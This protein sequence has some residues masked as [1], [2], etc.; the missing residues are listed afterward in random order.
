MIQTRT[1]R[2]ALGFAAFLALAASSPASDAPFGQDAGSLP[3]SPTPAGFV[4]PAPVAALPAPGVL[5]LEARIQALINEVAA[6]RSGPAAARA[7]AARTFSEAIHRSRAAAGNHTRRELEA[8]LDSGRAYLQH[9]Q[10]RDAAREA[11]VPRLQALGA[12]LSERI[13]QDLTHPERI[14]ADLAAAP[15]FDRPSL[16]RA[17]ACFDRSAHQVPGVAPSLEY[18]ELP[19]PGAPGA[20]PSPTPAGSSS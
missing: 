20:S 1:T 2:T 6:Y 9:Q 19:A 7:D 16:A 5:D 18:P 13:R 3:G 12:E 4:A 14:R 11:L 15:H 17:K 10:T 8:L